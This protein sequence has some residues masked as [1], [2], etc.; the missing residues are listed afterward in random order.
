[1]LMKIYKILSLIVF[2]YASLSLAD[3][4]TYYGYITSAT[5]NFQGSNPQYGTTLYIKNT[6]P[7]PG[8]ING[9]DGNSLAVIPSNTKITQFENYVVPFDRSGGKI[10]IWVVDNST[11]QVVNAAILYDKDDIIHFDQ[12]S[13]L[14]PKLSFEVKRIGSSLG[15]IKSG[16][17]NALYST[18]NGLKMN[19]IDDVYMPSDPENHPK[20]LNNT[21]AD[22]NK[23]YCLE[24]SA[25]S[26]GNASS[27]HNVSIDI[28]AES[29]GLIQAVFTCVGM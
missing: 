5:N 23:A 27:M 14:V 11:K 12:D 16:H 1:M 25:P 22:W 3:G 10:Y 26:T 8:K 17:Y 2:L 29:D 7:H 13:A 21:F 20:Y 9:G 4:G 15:L 24:C 28:I 18:C 19:Y 6:D